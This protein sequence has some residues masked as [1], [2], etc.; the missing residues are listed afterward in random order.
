MTDAPER[1]DAP[2]ELGFT[3]KPMVPWL[4]PQFLI[5]AGL[6]VVVSG[7][8]ARFADKREVEAGLPTWV[9]RTLPEGARP[10]DPADDDPEWGP[11]GRY[12][13]AAARD[14][15][16]R[17]WIDYAADVGE[18]FDPTYTVASLLAREEL[19]VGG[20]ETRRGRILVLGGDQ[21][22]PSASWD[23]YRDR[24]VGP[25]RAA[26]P[27][28]DS[29]PDL[30][31]IPGNHDW[32]DGLTSFMRLF[33]QGSWIGGWQT[34][35]GRSYFALRLSARWWLWATD[36]QL[37]TYLDGPQLAY[38]RRAA[39]QLGEGDRVILA[40]A[41]PSWVDAEPPEPGEVKPETSWD[42]LSFVEEKLIA[43]TGAKV[44][45]TIT[46]DKHHYVR[47]Q[48]EGEYW[49]RE[50]L[51]AGGGGAHTSAT[52]DLPPY[53]HLT[54]L[55]ATDSLSYK[56]LGVSPSPSESLDMRR[57][58]L[59]GLRDQTK[60]GAFI[61]ALY[62]LIALSVADALKDLASGLST[63][64]APDTFWAL[65]GDSISVWSLGLCVLLFL[66]LKA[67]VDAEPPRGGPNSESRRRRERAVKRK[68][69]ALGTLHTLMHL[70]PAVGLTWL[71]LWLMRDSD[72]AADGLAAGWVTAVFLFAVGFLYGRAAFGLYLLIANEND[73]RQ[74]TT[75]MYG[76]L[77]STKHKNF[78]RFAL[79]DETLTIYPVGIAHSPGW[80]LKRPDEPDEPGDPWFV[81]KEAGQ[82]AVKL[83][84]N[85]PITLSAPA[86]A[87]TPRDEAPTETL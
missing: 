84:E 37:D 40:T 72:L 74:H 14:E 51:T 64:V 25:Y 2:G 73:A 42:A 33:C 69:R 38:F 10:P 18:G 55:D 52:H 32:Y 8:F 27:W 83:L 66:G 82:P 35:Q 63:S 70:V 76:G 62:A 61:G 53:L 9:T 54:P 75:E 46:G 4:A 16:G 59:R 65:L 17:L 19:T 50:R 41:K 21:V 28:A 57:D 58:A 12:A 26:L 87:G 43:S 20:N 30:Y 34:R 3:P 24:F 47:Y 45:V 60:L 44:A 1:P 39:R 79:K 23:E 71:L 48:G 77:A 31:A 15:D 36:I 85:E 7:L 6:E 78:L 67:F 11:D 56:R 68:R 49:P 22:Y 13:K 80:R 29:P 81:S 5:K 86:P